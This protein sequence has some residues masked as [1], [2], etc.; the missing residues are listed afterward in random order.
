MSTFAWHSAQS[1]AKTKDASSVD[2]KVLELDIFRAILT[3]FIKSLMR[4]VCQRAAQSERR[5][6][7]YEGAAFWGIR[8]SRDEMDESPECF[9]LSVHPFLRKPRVR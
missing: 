1:H 3:W 8:Y 4:R 7:R 5:A 6:L 2:G 9:R